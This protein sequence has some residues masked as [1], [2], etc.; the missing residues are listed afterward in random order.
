MVHNAIT[1]HIVTSGD[2][3]MVAAGQRLFDCP[4]CRA[5]RDAKIF[6]N[7]APG[8]LVAYTID[9]ATLQPIT[10]DST[11]LNSVTG[12]LYIGVGVDTDGDGA[13][14][15]V[16]LLA[17]EK[18]DKCLLDETSVSAPV[19]GQ[20]Q[21]LAAYLD[22]VKCWETYAVQFRYS[23]NRT[24]SFGL[25]RAD[26]NEITAAIAPECS[27]CDD[28]SPTANCEEVICKLVDALNNEFD[29]TLS[30]GDAYPDKK[31][32]HT[33]QPYRAVRLHD[34]WNVF[35]INPTG[36]ACDCE[37]CI[38]TDVIESAVINGTVVNFSGNVNPSNNAQTLLAQLKNIAQQIE[39]A[40]DDLIGPHSGFA[41]VASGGPDSCCPWQLHVVTCDDDFELHG[42]SGALDVCDAINPYPGFASRATCVDCGESP[43]ADYVPTCGLAVIIEQP[44]IDCGCFIDKPLAWYGRMGD[45]TFVKDLDSYSPIVKATELLAPRFPEN[46]GAWI[47]W[48]EY[49]QE[50]GGKGREY[51]DVNARQGWLGLPDQVSRARNAITFADCNKSYCTYYLGHFN[52][53]RPV[54]DRVNL[55][56]VNRL[57]SYIHI[58]SDDVS[59]LNSWETFYNA[60]LTIGES[61]CKIFGDVTC[62]QVEG[63]PTYVPANTGVPA[64]SPAYTPSY[65]PTYTPTY[66]PTYAPTYS[67]AAYTPTYTPGG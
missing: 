40:F 57:S 47:Q 37:G 44:E 13:A 22:C 10:V 17:G 31:V 18:L 61:T 65:D 48:L 23:D 64:S 3:T 59:T 26:Q 7:V 5:G 34:N 46:F 35:C 12:D 41:F 27:S 25:N 52:R 24:R 38:A 36:A 39:C 1:K 55:S 51:R 66:T 67:P 60:L 53:R 58:P 32:V 43:A 8:Q 21:I 33:T 28:C 6:Y 30:N 20:P 4:N 42:A 15:D 50:T 14:D 49:S 11:T 62:L 9:S 29:Y 16:R 54:I 63:T 45:L 56:N 2:Y 19:C